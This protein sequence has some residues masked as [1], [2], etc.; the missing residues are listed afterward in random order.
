[1]VLNQ[2]PNFKKLPH[3]IKSNRLFKHTINNEK[4]AKI[5]WSDCGVLK[6]CKKIIVG[7]AFI[8][9]YLQLSM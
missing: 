5:E 4:Q 8:C 6:K 7:S 1:V 9:S 3:P 2:A